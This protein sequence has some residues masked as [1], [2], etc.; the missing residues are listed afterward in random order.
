MRK[1]FLL[2]PLVLLLSG[3]PIQ[4]SQGML[5]TQKTR[6]AVSAVDYVGTAGS[7][8]LTS[9]PYTIEAINDLSDITLTAKFLDANQAI[10]EIDTEVISIIPA[11]SGKTVTFR[12]SYGNALKVQ[13]YQIIVDATATYYDRVFG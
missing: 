4:T 6:D 3:C 8:G 9:I 1:M 2:A 7:Q 5:V 11:G 10:L 13:Y 12:F